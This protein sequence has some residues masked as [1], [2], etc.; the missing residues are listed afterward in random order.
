MWNIAT[1]QVE[2]ALEGHSDLVRSVAFSLDGSK[3]HSFYSVDGSWVTQN[4]LRILYL[5]LNHRPGQVAT[6]GSSLVTGAAS[7]RVTII[8]FRS[9]V[10][11]GTI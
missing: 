3:S 6:E 11:V 1:G 8:I 7:G 5:P 2:Q 9:D 10:K 4:G